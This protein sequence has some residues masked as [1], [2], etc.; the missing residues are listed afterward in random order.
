MILQNS[1]P[2]AVPVSLQFLIYGY[3]DLFNFNHEKRS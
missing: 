1:L 3:F 2:E